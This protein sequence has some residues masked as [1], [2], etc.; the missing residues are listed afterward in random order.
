[1]E[2]IVIMSGRTDQDSN[3]IE[4]L[5]VLFPECEIDVQNREYANYDSF[6][7]F[8]DESDDAELNEELEKYLAFL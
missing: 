2:K 8:K 5:R 6:E 4:C 7:L 1:M 3:L